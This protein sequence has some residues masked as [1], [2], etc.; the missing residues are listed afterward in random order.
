MLEDYILTIIGLTHLNI[1]FIPELM[2]YLDLDEDGVTQ[3]VINPN[4]LDTEDAEMAEEKSARTGCSGTVQTP[5]SG[6]RVKD[7]DQGGGL[8]WH[9]TAPISG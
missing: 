4:I 8:A 5:V 3:A 2:D 9:Q 1:F 6:A 7:G